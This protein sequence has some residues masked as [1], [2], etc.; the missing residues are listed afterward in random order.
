[1]SAAKIRIEIDDGGFKLTITGEYRQL[2]RPSRLSFTWCSSTWRPEEPESIVTV[3]LEPQGDDH[4]LMTIR[5]EQLPPAVLEG[6]EAGWVL[7]A[8][9]IAGWLERRAAPGQYP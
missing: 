6:H 8:D 4:T 2:E 3:V 5:H 1:M 9:Q 7:I